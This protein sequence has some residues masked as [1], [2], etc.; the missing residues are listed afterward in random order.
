ML[1]GQSKDPELSNHRASRLGLVLTPCT[2]SWA[3]KLCHLVGN[4]TC[5]FKNRILAQEGTS[6]SAQQ[7][8]RAGRRVELPLGALTL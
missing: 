4:D 3:A 6:E 5:N 7:G 8:E 1:P 2:W